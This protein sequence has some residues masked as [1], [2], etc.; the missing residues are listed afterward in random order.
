MSLEGANFFN[1][2]YAFKA[3]AC[4]WRAYG[5]RP[6]SAKSYYGGT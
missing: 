1:Y 3:A 4:R 6:W 5:A 2:L